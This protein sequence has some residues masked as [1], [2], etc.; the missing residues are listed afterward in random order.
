MK[1]STPKGSFT[2]FFS[3]GKQVTVFFKPRFSADRVLYLQR[4]D[5]VDTVLMSPPPTL[6]DDVLEEENGNSALTAQEQ[7]VVDKATYECINSPLHGTLRHRRTFRHSWEDNSEEEAQELLDLPCSIIPQH[8]WSAEDGEQNGTDMPRDC[9]AL[10]L[11]SETSSSSSSSP[12]SSSSSDSSNDDD[13]AF[14][15]D[16]DLHSPGHNQ[17][18]EVS[19]MSLKRED[20]KI[21]TWEFL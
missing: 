2:D 4:G 7:T 20:L 14:A 5:S 12:S 19:C 18:W 21:L 17:D 10:D 15:A 16:D 9:V 3:M 6:P 13:D 1:Q 11:G 8:L